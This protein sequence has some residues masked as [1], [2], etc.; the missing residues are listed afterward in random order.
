MTHSES[1][2]TQPAVPNGIIDLPGTYGRPW[3]LYNHLIRQIP[4][5][6]TVRDYALGV[7]WSYVQADCGTGVAWTMRGGSPRASR[8][9]LRGLPLRAVAE[10]AKSWCFEEATLGMAALNA[11]YNQRERLEALGA[12][13]EEKQSEDGS[14]VT[15]VFD[16]F[17]PRMRDRNVVVVGHF[18]RIERL[19]EH[20]NL[21]VLERAVRHEADLPDPACEYA[22][23]EADF[24]FIT[25][26]S[27]TN[28][29][30]P[31]LLD[32]ARD[33]STVMVGPSVTMSSFLH[34][35]GVDL[36]AGSVVRDPE[37]LSFIVR[38]GTGKLFDEALATVTLAAPA[39]ASVKG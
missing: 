15:D 1:R 23:P 16:R 19:G 22:L 32:L 9:D 38:N 35:W 29:T 27:L 26:V 10:L 37:R 36:L 25:G 3:K 5:H 17:L 14:R 8:P 30:A 18:P 39:P 7:R 31:R 34:R 12:V 13:F 28:K 20:A 6:L 2:C 4:E 24:A 21:T 33:A 11:F